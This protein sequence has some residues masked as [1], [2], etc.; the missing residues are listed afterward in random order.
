M[1][2]PILVCGCGMRIRAPGARPGRV[3]RCPSCGGRLEV[4]APP[5]LPDRAAAPIGLADGGDRGFGP[6]REIVLSPARARSEPEKPG[7]R[8]RSEAP[9]LIGRT[10]MTDGLLPVQREPETSWPVSFLYPMRGAESLA[11]VAAIGVLAWIFTVLVPEYGIQAMLDT[12]KMG[13]SLLGK[14]FVGLAV[15]PVLLLGPLVLSYWLQYLGRVLVSSAMGEC[16][17]PR[18]PD[19]N[20]DGFFSGLSPWLIWAVLGLG[21]GLGPAIWWGLAVGGL[22]GGVPWASVRLAVLGLPYV[23]AALMLCFLHEHA[24]A[25]T[26]WGVLR[27]LFRLGASFQLLSG[28]IAA[29]L[30]LIAGG[31][32]LILWVRG[33]LF[34]PYLLM[35]LFW[36]I[37]FLWV[38]VVTMRLLG[39]FYFHRKRALDWNRAHPRWGVAWRL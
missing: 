31:L 35:A 17:P 6:V 15:L 10:P 19:R 25:A 12:E 30:G 26:P 36:W 18:T 9:G 32:G 34:W 20:F 28:L 1:D 11:I 3:G 5:D 2:V 24:L 8:R 33:H 4:P 23:L 13:A 16:I 14:L 21:I 38:Q 27:G 29:A 39:I 37:A 22:G 7:R